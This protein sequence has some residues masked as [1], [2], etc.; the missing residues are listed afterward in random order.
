MKIKRIYGEF[1]KENILNLIIIIL[2]GEVL[3][4]VAD[5]LLLP[6]Y[7]DAIESS[8]K[9]LSKELFLGLVIKAIILLSL[10]IVSTYI[11]SVSAKRL[12]EKCSMFLKIKLIDIITNINTHEEIR[13]VGSYT[14]AL[15]R[16]EDIKDY[17]FI[18]V[19]ATLK[20]G[21]IL[22]LNFYLIFYVHWILVLILIVLILILMSLQLLIQ[23]LQ[24]KQQKIWKEEEKSLLYIDSQIQNLHL[25]RTYMIADV[26]NLKFSKHME[27]LLRMEKTKIFLTVLIE[28]VQQLSKIMVILMT[29]CICWILISR[30]IISVNT[31]II[32]SF[33]FF[34]M[35]NA[36]IEFIQNITEINRKNAAFMAIDDSINYERIKNKSNFFIQENKKAIIFNDVEFSFKNNII[37]RRCNLEFPN[38]GMVVITGASGSGKSSILKLITGHFRM[39]RGEILIYG[40][41]ASLENMRYFSISTQDDILFPGTVW[42]NIA[43]AA[44]GYTREAVDKVIKQLGMTECITELT[45]GLDTDINEEFT[46]LSGGQKQII[47]ICRALCKEA[48]ILMLDEPT[49]AQSER[50]ESVIIRSLKI[51][52]KNRLVIIV[53]HSIA[54][55]KNADFHYEMQEEIIKR[56]II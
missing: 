20:G 32:A 8:F 9:H 49:S 31:V 1:I 24:D 41:P 50:M 15:E 43:Y 26:L 55:I 7:N 3:S 14:K 19:S 23:P 37:L 11:T 38:Q 52:S 18:C 35:A 17:F 30:K 53:S 36:T 12:S 40:E 42:E 13:T 51:I 22:C 10:Y 33:S 34:L 29:P 44:K 47:C 48:P 25:I 21:F 28:L 39:Y 16:I 5:L 56:K 27:H 46:N 45:N 2:L 4:N 6:L 54:V